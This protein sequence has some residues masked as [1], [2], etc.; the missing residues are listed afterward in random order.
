MLGTV[1]YLV[2]ILLFFGLGY[3]RK[4]LDHFGL[5]E[6][7]GDV[8]FIGAFAFDALSSVRHLISGNFMQFGVGFCISSLFVWYFYKQLMRN[9]YR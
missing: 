1:V 6:R 8:M 7:D 3:F 9:Y 5:S 4:T 2:L